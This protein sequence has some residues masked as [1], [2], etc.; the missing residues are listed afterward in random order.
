MR[1]VFNV[2]QIFTGNFHHSDSLECC[3]VADDVIT[4]VESD[5]EPVLGPSGS[6]RTLNET[7]LW[8][9]NKSN[10]TFLN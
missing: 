2:K 4:Y 3:Y 1:G 8:N 10:K 5:V 9:S 6:V 7:L